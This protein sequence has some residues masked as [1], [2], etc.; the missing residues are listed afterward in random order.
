MGPF[1]EPKPILPPF[2]IDPHVV[3]TKAGLF[4]YY[5]TNHYDVDRV[6]TCIVVDRLL[7]PFTPE[8]KPVTVVEPTLDEDRKS[9]V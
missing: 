1:S 6:G 2:S 5:S 4:I 9:V 3:Q 8:G 7:D